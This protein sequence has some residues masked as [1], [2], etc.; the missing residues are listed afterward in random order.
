MITSRT[1]FG[2]P[3]GRTVALCCVMCGVAACTPRSNNSEIAT[4]LAPTGPQSVS[5]VSFNG[6]HWGRPAQ[7][8][9]AAASLLFAANPDLVALQE[10]NTGES[11][12]VAVNDLARALSA[13]LKTKYCV[14]FSDLP[15]EARE[16]YALLWRE[17]T[18]AYVTTTGEVKSRCLPQAVTLPLFNRKAEEIVREPVYAM[19]QT[20]GSQKKFIASTVHLV[21]SGKKPQHEVA[22]VFDSL[23]QKG[24]DFANIPLILMGDFN[25]SNAHP[26]FEVIKSQGFSA[27][28]AP[29]TKT[30]LKMKKREYSKEYDQF[31]T[32]G[33]TCSEGERID[34]YA[35][36]PGMSGEDIYNNISD[37]A[38][39]RT[40]CM[41]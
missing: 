28:M 1:F 6:K 22:P 29:R 40:S 37:H 36:L 4:E 7:D 27:M 5:I 19:F 38:P 41:L 14:A 12:V 21:P 17:T 34:V 2:K 9:E 13:K 3:L 15:S 23:P 33:L 10:V 20:K 8:I 30:S 16:R 26:V 31:F 18:L 35:L 11:G 25:L 39:I 32:R 24:E